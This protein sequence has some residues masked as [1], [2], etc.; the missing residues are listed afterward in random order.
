MTEISVQDALKRAIAYHQAGRLADAET[1]YR[2]ILARQPNHADALH[3]LGLIALRSGHRDQAI[4]LIRRAIAIHPTWAEAIYN[5]GVALKEAGQLEA[6]IEAHRRVLRLDQN[7]APARAALADGLNEWAVSQQ[8]AGELDRAIACYREAIA[9]RPGH[10]PASNN[11]SIALATSASKLQDR[12]EL[13]E[14]IAAYRQAIELRPTHAGLHNNLGNALIDIGATTDAV[15]AYRIAHQLEPSNA[16]M[17]SALIC[18]MQYG[19]AFSEEAIASERARWNALH[20]GSLSPG[21]RDRTDRLRIGYVSAD[22]RDH[23]VGR[24]LLPLLANHDRNRFEVFCYSNAP[25]DDAVTERIRSQ[26]DHWRVIAG[27]SDDWTVDLIQADGVD[28]LVDLSG[29]TTGNRLPMFARKP[30]PVQISY[31][32]YPASTGLTAIDWRLTD[33]HADRDGDRLIRLPRTNW[34]FQAP[35]ESPA[36]SPLPLSYR[37]FVTFGSFNHLAK[38]SDEMIAMWSQIL[39]RVEKSRMVLKAAALSARS[40][41][42]RVLSAFVANGIDPERIDLR[43]HE[44]DFAS[45][46]QAYSSIDI[47]L[48]T[49]PYHGTTTTCEALWMGVPVITMA[50]QVHASRVGVSL[51]TNLQLTELIAVDAVEYVIAATELASDIDRLSALRNGL[52]ERMRQSPLMDAAGFT[53][54]FENAVRS[55]WQQA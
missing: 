9:V 42:D 8:Q 15:H 20:A 21:D 28:I 26:A 31:L 22:F 43:G 44:P 41:R 10:G 19:P 51:L 38:V 25:L 45:H 48:D 14:A 7:S 50:G 24:F 12:G 54:D 1:I 37:G 23:P 16:S 40:A 11:L 27:L 39:H 29:H 33:V 36:V 32:G 18:A 46:L 55:A 4:E 17:H 5:L 35:A 6:A 49:F 13:D 53:T 34:C 2:Q 3:L 30:A 47:A 52:G